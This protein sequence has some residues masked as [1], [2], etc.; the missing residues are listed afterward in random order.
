[1]EKILKDIVYP[2][3]PNLLVGIETRDDAGVYRISDETAL[4]QTVD[5]FTPMVDDAYTFG[6]I[7]ATNAINDIYAMG[8]K[9]LL[10]LN[11]VCY[12]QC[13][14]M[15]QLRDILL[16]GLSKVTEAGAFLLGGHTVDDLE[17]KYG[18]AV[19]GL[20]HPDRV[21]GNRGA[22][23]GD[24]IFLTKPL[25][26]GIISTA[27]KAEMSSPEACQEAIRWMTLLNKDAC[28]A[29]LESGVNA[30]TDV[31][32]FGLLGHLYEL[33][34]ASDVAIEISAA[35]IPFMESA[36]EYARWGL[37]PG[38]AYTNREYLDDKV[39]IDKEIEQ[40]I[41]D[42]V[43][44]PETAGGLLISVPQSRAAVLSSELDRRGCSYFQIGRVT[45]SP[46]KRIHVIP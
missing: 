46:F 24:L 32:G 35:S 39:Y 38:G 9:P 37:V 13:E 27:I 30:V 21:L 45:G 41:I 8:G 31:T 11:I 36:L 25:G 23:E 40:A 4:I 43:F 12:P 29:M 17:P 10:A 44:S 26:N 6:Q 5:F 18:L 34:A 14:D 7:A 42:G 19:T 1:M 2:T 22:A 33:A 28:E 16:G 15:M 3:D 20:V